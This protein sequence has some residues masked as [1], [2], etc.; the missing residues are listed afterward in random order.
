MPDRHVT[1]TA[2][3]RYNPSNP[4]EPSGSGQ[5]GV[6]EH[7]QGDIN[8][9]GMVDV[10]DAVLLLNYYLVGN[11]TPEIITLCDMNADGTVDV[12]DAVQ[13]LNKFMIE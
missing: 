12:T 8:A 11:P 9:D 1:L 10:S 3:Y 7:S 6:Q 5:E 13:V 2:R 4:N